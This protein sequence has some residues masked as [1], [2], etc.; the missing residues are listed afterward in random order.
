MITIRRFSSTREAYDG[1]QIGEA[2]KGDLLWIPTEKVVGIADTWPVALT[3]EYGALHHI[4]PC[5]AGQAWL[6]EHDD[7]VLAANE[8]IAALNY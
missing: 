6:A 4:S 8:L 2:N 5:A 7:A 1:C 3:R